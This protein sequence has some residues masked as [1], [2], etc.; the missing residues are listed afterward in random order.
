M[1]LNIVENEILAVIGPNGAGKTTLLEIIVGLRKADQ[2][3][4]NYWDPLFKE[5]IGV[6]LQSVPFF[7][8][9]TTIENIKLFAAF[10]KKRIST[11]KVLALLSSCG[12]EKVG[13]TEATRLS[14]GQQKRLAIAIAMVHNPKLLFLDEPTSALDPRSRKEIHQ[15]IQQ[16]FQLGT[17]IVFTSHDMGEVMNLASRLLMIDQ[18]KIVAEGHPQELCQQ[19][20]VDNLESLYLHL[21]DKEEMTND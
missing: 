13:D 15:L 9:L 4:V 10:Y 20:D 21:T 17:T 16:L 2:G 6:Q 1:S 7:P 14:G 11:E 18:G 5:Y 12:L 8:G 19:Y 3:E